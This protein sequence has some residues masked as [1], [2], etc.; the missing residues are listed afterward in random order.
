MGSKRITHPLSWILSILVEA[1]TL[2]HGAA[3]TNP[4][5]MIYSFGGGPDGEYLDTDLVIDKAGNI[6]GTSVQGG[7]HS[8]GTV[9]RLSPSANG[10][11]HTVLYNF[12]GGTDGGEPYKGVALD[13]QGNL[14][15][16]A[17]VGGKF[18]GPCSDT[19]CGVVFKLTNSSRVWTYK[20]IHSFTGGS[21]GYGPGS[22]PVVDKHGNVYGMTPTGGTNACACGVVF[23]LKPEADGHWEFTVIHAFVGGNDGIG[24]SAGRPLL[25]HAGNLYSVSTAG[26]ANGKGIAFQLRHTEEGSWKQTILYTFKGL[27]DAGFP[28]SG[29]TFDAEGNLYGTTYY[30]GANGDGSVYQLSHQ[31]D[32]SWKERVLYSFKGGA[33]GSGPIGTLVFAKGNLL[34]TTSADGSAACGCGTIFKLAS[35]GGDLWEESVVFRFPGAPK[36][37]FAYNGMT[38][39]SLG[40][41]FGATVHGGTTDDGAIY[42]LTP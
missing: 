8:S 13:A 38:P 9:W 22:P 42:K 20:V 31:D 26:G 25:D 18:V 5:Q 37:A 7:A 12:R 23:Q 15:G 1:A 28:Y 27:P 39:D 36:P 10:W 33:D 40:N 29:L 4:P 3:A 34:G 19:G 16:T 14:Y 11:T 24:G 17:G 32:G 21:D 35:L 6:Y 2:V 30:D 41:L